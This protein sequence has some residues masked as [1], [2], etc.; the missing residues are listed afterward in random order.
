[1]NDRQRKFAEYYAQCGNVVQ[2]AIKAG[3]SEKYANA[4]AYKLLENIGVAEYLRTL[5]G[6]AQNVR[7]LTAVKRQELLSE[8]A[9]DNAIEPKDRIKAID[10]LN[11]MTGEYT[12][13]VDTTVQPSKKLAE[14][15]NQIGGEGLR[16]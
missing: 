2:S 16:E 8:L 1:M 13:K 14:I 12:V 4:L 10:V 11:K 5:T 7:I 3:Y 9:E 6:M 15:M